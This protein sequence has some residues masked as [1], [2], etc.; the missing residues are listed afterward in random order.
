[1]RG[2]VEQ[3]RWP[4]TCVTNT[5]GVKTGGVTL[6]LQEQGR[7]ALSPSPRHL[8]CRECCMRGEGGVMD[9]EVLLPLIYFSVCVLSICL[10]LSFPIPQKINL[11]VLLLFLEI[12]DMYICCCYIH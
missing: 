12:I 1:M 2:T 3:R 9:G 5:L 6:A 10:I 7:R 8:P 11:S 4:D